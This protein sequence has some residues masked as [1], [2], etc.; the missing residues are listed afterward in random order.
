M[1]WLCFFVLSLSPSHI[2]L[3]DFK[4]HSIDNI[5]AV[6]PKNTTTSKRVRILALKRQ[7][8]FERYKALEGVDD[9]DYDLYSVI[10]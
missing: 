7:L 9:N 1:N 5:I 3:L 8:I 6:L 2:K 10:K 4:I